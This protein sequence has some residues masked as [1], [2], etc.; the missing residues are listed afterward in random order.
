[1]LSRDDVFALADTLTRSEA[2]AFRKALLARS[3]TF[4]IPLKAMPSDDLIYAL[5]QSKLSCFLPAD[6]EPQEC[7]GKWF[8]VCE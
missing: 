1:M 7:A 2:T 5:D 8:L 3:E 6:V 4:E